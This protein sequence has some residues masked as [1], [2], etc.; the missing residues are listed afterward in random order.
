MQTTLIILILLVINSFF[1]I[2]EYS[3]ASS[4]KSKLQQLKNDGIYVA[5]E[6]I[7]IIDSPSKFITVI[8]IGLNLVAIVSGVIGEKNLSDF[9]SQ[10]LIVYGLSADISSAIASSISILLIASV[11]ILF[12]ELIPKKIAFSNPEV[13]ACK[14]VKPLIFTMKVFYPL[15]RV[16]SQLSVVILNFFKVDTSRDEHITIEE[17][18]ALISESAEN[19]VLEKSEHRII[20]NV[21]SLADRNITNAITTID[22]IKYLNIDDT[23]DEINKKL[24]EHPHARFIVTDGGLDNILGYIDSRDILCKNLTNKPLTLN[25][26]KLKEQG[27]KNILTLPDSINLL[28]VLEKF[29]D[30]HEDIACVT[31]EFGMVVGIITLND[32]LTTLM[33]DVVVTNESESMIVSRGDNSWI[34]DG[35]ASIEELKQVLGLD[36]IESGNNF[37]TVNGFIMYELKSLPKKAQK[38]KL[39]GYTFEIIDIDGFRIDDV[40]ITKN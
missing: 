14:I 16:L 30:S 23:T 12:S 25:R 17:V 22:K 20:E 27:V 19:G 7:N 37:E 4:R 3:I 40:L 1:A 15:E 2:S 5:D 33:G 35:R 28:D 18:S 38:I 11:F 8:Q 10:Y 26:D 31:N 36:E 13:I 21:L 24:I 29:K 6:V 32:I 39:Y 34:V 9:I